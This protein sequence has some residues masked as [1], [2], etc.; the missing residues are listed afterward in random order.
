MSDYSIE[1]FYDVVTVLL[2]YL[3]QSSLQ[4]LNI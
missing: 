2:G 4:L 1:I 3:D